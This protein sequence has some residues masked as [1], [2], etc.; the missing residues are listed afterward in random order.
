MYTDYDPNSDVLT[1]VTFGSMN[2][3]LP[4][5]LHIVRVDARKLEVVDAMNISR[6]ES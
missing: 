1:F 3:L 6:Q 2:P 4:S 5:S